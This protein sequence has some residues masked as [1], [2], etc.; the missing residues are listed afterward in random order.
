MQILNGKIIA[1]QITSEL[2]E[3]FKILNEQ[4]GRKPKLA[5]IQVGN[6][7]ASNRYIEIK[8]RKAKELNVETAVYNFPDNV[9]Q[10]K[11]LKALDD[12]NEDADGIIVQLPLNENLSSQVILD[13]VRHEKDIDGLSTRNAFNFYNETGEFCFTPATAEAIMTLLKYYKIEL[14]DKKISVIGRSAL[15]GKPTATLLK[16]E[17]GIVSTYSKSTGIKG[18]ESADLI[19]SATGVPNLISKENIKENSVV[20]D[21]GASVMNVDGK[22]VLVGDVNTEGLEDHI[23]ALSPVPGGI[24]PLTVCSLFKNLAK[25]IRHNNHL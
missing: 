11:I 2:K 22:N 3:E 1:D 17:N 16:K 13:A 10:T 8:K 18:V 6:L 25:A 24:G 12:I 23:K 14:E 19:V 5:I 21:V 7:E 9:R 20:I 15:V 4:L